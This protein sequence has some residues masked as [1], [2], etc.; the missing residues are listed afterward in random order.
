[1]SPYRESP[2]CLSR[3]TSACSLVHHRGAY[4]ERNW[5]RSVAIPLPILREVLSPGTQVC[6][7]DSA[8][9]PP[10]PVSSSPRKTPRDSSA[11]STNFLPSV[12]SR[13]EAGGVLLPMSS[14]NVYATTHAECSSH[15]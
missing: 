2:A 15:F 12:S 9:V 5:V 4:P 10:T 1:M 7:S 13:T 14:G 6:P 11:G 3:L 8:S